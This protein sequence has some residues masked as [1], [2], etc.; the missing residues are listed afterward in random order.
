MLE[1]GVCITLIIG[2]RRAVFE[3]RFDFECRRKQGTVRERCLVLFVGDRREVFQGH[4]L[5]LIL[6]DS[7]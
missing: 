5:T 3:S 1:S 7:R 6:R 2:E 4:C